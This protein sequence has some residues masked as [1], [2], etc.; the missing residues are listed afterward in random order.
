MTPFWSGVTSGA[1]M[2]AILLCLGI[3]FWS[4]KFWTAYTVMAVTDSF[5]WAVTER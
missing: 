3:E 5:L 1:V 2:A 4:W